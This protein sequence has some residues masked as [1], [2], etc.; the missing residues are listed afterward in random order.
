MDKDAKTIC[1]TAHGAQSRNPGRQKKERYVLS[2]VLQINAR[3]LE[4]H[5]I[6]SSARINL[7]NITKIEY[8]RTTFCAELE[9]GKKIKS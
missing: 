8:I 1:R 2:C 7:T 4:L 6:V 3:L 5:P 9:E